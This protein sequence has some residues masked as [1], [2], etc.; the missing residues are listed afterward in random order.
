[1]IGS[2]RAAVRRGVPMPW[3]QF[4]G[5]RLT[6][7]TM[8]LLF[9]L[10]IPDNG[11][12]R[13]IRGDLLRDLQM[14]QRAYAWTTEMAVKARLRGARIDWC[15]TDFRVRR[16]DSK[17]AGTVRGTLGAALGIFGTLL[18]LRLGAHRHTQ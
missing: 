3:H 13:A 15:E 6:V 2:R 7:F 1:M 8:R 14:E 12:F 4:L 10:R 5:E 17:I 9:G 18:R 16:G 11:P